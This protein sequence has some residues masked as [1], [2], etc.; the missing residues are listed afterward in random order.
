MVS[1]AF[2]KGVSDL[3]GET[4]LRGAGK[5][6]EA[7]EVAQVRKMVAQTREWPQRGKE[8]Y[9]QQLGSWGHSL[10]L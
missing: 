2:W 4:G 9:V 6:A 7:D 5:P 10:S 1:L 3:D 8:G